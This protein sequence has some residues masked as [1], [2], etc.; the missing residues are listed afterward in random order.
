VVLL[1]NSPR[2]LSECECVGFVGRTLS[3]LMLPL[4]CH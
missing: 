2:L 4:T 3:I 1:P